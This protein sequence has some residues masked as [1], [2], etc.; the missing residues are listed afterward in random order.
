VV[1]VFSNH[2]ADD[3]YY[4][5]NKSFFPDVYSFQY[6]NGT[7]IAAAITAK[8]QNAG[9]GRKPSIIPTKKKKIK[10]VHPKQ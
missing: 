6:N 2:I 9:K 7:P 1:T 8:S 4:Y 5:P 10:V 3:K